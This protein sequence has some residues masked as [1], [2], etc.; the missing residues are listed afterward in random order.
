MTCGAGMAVLVLSSSFIRIEESET[1]SKI[2]FDKEKMQILSLL[3]LL[4]IAGTYIEKEVFS[5]STLI[6]AF[7]IFLLVLALSVFCALKPAFVFKKK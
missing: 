5:E 4:G 6:S 3:C 7:S 1:E 2:L